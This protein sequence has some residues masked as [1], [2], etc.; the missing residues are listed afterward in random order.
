M[1]IIGDDIFRLIPQ[2]NP[3]VM[4]DEFEATGENTALTALYVRTDNLFLLSDGTLAETGLIE[5]IA[6]SAAALVGYQQK[7]LKEPRIGLIGEVKRFACLHRPKSGQ[8]VRTNI[9]FTLTIGNVTVVDGR[10]CIGDE[11]I[12]NAKLILIIVEMLLK[13][14]VMQMFLQIVNIFATMKVVNVSQE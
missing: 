10:C 1:K 9:E 4:V 12:A 3:F 14:N 7:D 6:Q 11:E 5:H 13:L 2:R 8:I